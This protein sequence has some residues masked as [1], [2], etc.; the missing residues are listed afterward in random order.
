MRGVGLDVLIVDPG[1][2]EQ[3]R[4]LEV[5]EC[6][7]PVDVCRLHLMARNDQDVI[8]HPAA[9]EVFQHGEGVRPNGG[10]ERVGR[11]VEHLDRRHMRLEVA[12]VDQ[13]F[14]GLRVG[15]QGT[16]HPL[17]PE[18]IGVSDAVRAVQGAA[19]DVVQAES[20]LAVL[21]N[22]AGAC[23]KSVDLFPAQQ[24]DTCRHLAHSQSQKGRTRFTV[25][26]AA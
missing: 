15:H 25:R 22:L 20:A 12:M 3:Q 4:H 13:L 10:K 7:E 19:L 24:G 21:D 9:V 26:M 2:G 1:I 6:I 18:A 17:I 23:G 16:R 8:G 11:P 5:L 14:D